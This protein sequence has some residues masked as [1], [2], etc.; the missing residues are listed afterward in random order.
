MI[1]RNLIFFDLP[2][3]RGLILD[4]TFLPSPQSCWQA[5]NIISKRDLRFWQNA[6]RDTWGFPVAA[7]PRVPVPKSRV[8]S[9]SPTLAVI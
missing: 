8:V 7:N 4:R 3:H 1:R 6:D 9:L 2:E 5:L